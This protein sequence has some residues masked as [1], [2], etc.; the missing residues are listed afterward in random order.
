MK[1]PGG[2]NTHSQA[3]KQFDLVDVFT[4]RKEARVRENL[5]E[6]LGNKLF[7][8]RTNVIST[9][10]NVRRLVYR[11]HAVYVRQFEVYSS[12]VLATW[13]RER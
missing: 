5:R 13:A 9:V 6:I 7:C 12:R 1:P 2:A 11:K 10:I 3:M 4:G 8:Q